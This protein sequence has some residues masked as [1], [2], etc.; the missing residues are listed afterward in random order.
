LFWSGNFIIGRYIYEDVE[1]V[2]LA[3]FR[4]I[5][6]A[7]LLFPVLL[8]CFSNIIKVLKQNFFILNLLAILGVSVFNTILYV[9]LNYTKA[10]NALLI[11]S[12][13]PILI[14]I[15]SYFIL[16]TNIRMI[17]LMGIVL[18]TVGVVF[19]ILRGEFS[20]IS[21]IELNYG[22]IWVVA[23]SFAWSLYSVFAKFRP[24]GLG[25]FEFFTSIVY[26]GLF[27][28]VLVYLGMGYSFFEDI[29]LVKKHYPSF[30][31]VALFP[32]LLSY[33][34][35]HMGIREIGASRTGQFTHLMP[36]FGSI[37]AYIFL[38]EKLSLYHIVGAILVGLGIYLSLFTKKKTK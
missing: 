32:S 15:L 4:W 2:Q 29:V 1:P 19:L 10:T 33:Y 17:Q 27:W 34:F 24:K 25:D 7:I 6:V 30:L 26:I 21:T 37:M 35:W 8:V 9:G 16:K 5:G 36:L 11:N 3:V 14:L 18:S 31:Y 23:A 28:L 22:D 12:S 38:D 20:A 13:V